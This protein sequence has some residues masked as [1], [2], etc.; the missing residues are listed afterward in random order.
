[1][2]TFLMLAFWIPLFNNTK[3]N[4]LEA[5]NL[6]QNAFDPFQ[7]R[8]RIVDDWNKD[9][10]SSLIVTTESVC[11]DSHPKLAMSRT[12]HGTKAACEC[13]GDYYD[14]DDDG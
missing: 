11:P 12:W 9:T 3:N 14:V 10:F 4:G 13:N 1:M 6:Q 5:I 2:F 8:D 7:I